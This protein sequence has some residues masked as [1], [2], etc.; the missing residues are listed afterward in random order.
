MD[1][2]KGRLL[3]DCVCCHSIYYD[4]ANNGMLFLDR[5]ASIFFCG[6]DDAKLVHEASSDAVVDTGL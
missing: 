3:E 6:G 4:E 2:A 1:D 5:A